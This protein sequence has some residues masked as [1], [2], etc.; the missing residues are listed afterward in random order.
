MILDG[1]FGHAKGIGDLSIAVATYHEP[2]HLTLARGEEFRR[3]W[4]FWTKI[5]ALKVTQQM[6]RDAIRESGAPTVSVSGG[7]SARFATAA[8]A[9]DDLSSG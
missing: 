3:L 1:A 4:R 5:Q 7:W 6:F 8:R 9:I 2:N